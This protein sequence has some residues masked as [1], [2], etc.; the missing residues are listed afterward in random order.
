MLNDARKFLVG[1]RGRA[2][3]KVGPFGFDLTGDSSRQGID[4]N[5][6]ACLVRIVA[7]AMAVIGSAQQGVE[8]SK[9]MPARQELAHHAVWSAIVPRQNAQTRFSPP[10]L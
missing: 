8:V 10:R 4:Q 2:V 5:L 6:D 1:Q 3:F 7:A 9:Q